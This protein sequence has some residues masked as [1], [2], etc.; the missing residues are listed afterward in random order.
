MDPNRDNYIGGEHLH[1]VRCEGLHPFNERVGAATGNERNGADGR[2]RLVLDVHAGGCHAIGK[3]KRKDEATF[4]TMAHPLLWSVLGQ[5][6]DVPRR[7]L[8]W[9]PLA[10][11]ERF[12]LRR[13]LHFAVSLCFGSSTK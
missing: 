7:C 4:D 11:V 2:G 1:C 13:D 10:T 6:V 5:A 3:E 9:V 12:G 8:C